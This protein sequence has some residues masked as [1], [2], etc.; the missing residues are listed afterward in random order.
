MKKFNP[1][2]LFLCIAVFCVVMILSNPGKK[3][4]AVT[5]LKYM[6]TETDQTLNIERGISDQNLRLPM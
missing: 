6:N 1:F 4:S 3:L 2:S 5:G